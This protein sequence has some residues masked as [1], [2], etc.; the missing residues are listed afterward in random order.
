MSPAAA[1]T[2]A[3]TRHPPI[4]FF[5]FM[6]SLLAGQSSCAPITPGADRGSAQVA[7]PLLTSLR[8][9]QLQDAP[10]GDLR[11]RLRSR[12]VCNLNENIHDLAGVER[13]VVARD[14]L[15]HDLDNAC[16]DQFG[17]G[18]GDLCLG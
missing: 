5:A 13:R 10:S 17:V 1:I 11:K 6:G 7:G 15:K 3:A 18:V 16:I 14:H 12:I 4:L 8:S 9:S 2:A